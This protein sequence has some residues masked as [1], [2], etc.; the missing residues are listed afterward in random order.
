MTNIAL[1]VYPIFFT[2]SSILIHLVCFHVLNT[3]H[4]AAMNMGRVSGCP[5]RSLF[6]G[7]SCQPYLCPP[8]TIAQHAP[9]LH[10][11][12]SPSFWAQQQPYAI[13][14]S[15]VH[16]VVCSPGPLCGLCRGLAGQRPSRLGGTG[17]P[18]YLSAAGDLQR[19]PAARHHF[20]HIHSDH[21]GLF[22]FVFPYIVSLSS[23]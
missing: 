9:S 11:P 7:F 3:V 14:Y 2:H 13:P 22:C 15:N 4:S 5:G 6:P 10:A 20:T 19:S 8:W 21:F 23:T 17:G 18:Y 1:C 16:L 12:S